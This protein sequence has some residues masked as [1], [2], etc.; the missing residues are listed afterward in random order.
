MANFDAQV[1]TDFRDVAGMAVS[2][3][4]DDIVEDTSNLGFMRKWTNRAPGLPSIPFIRQPGDPPPTY[5]GGR[6]GDPENNTHASQPAIIL[7]GGGRQRAQ[8]DRA[9]SCQLITDIFDNAGDDLLANQPF[10]CAYQFEKR[11][12]ASNG[13]AI[14]SVDGAPSEFSLYRRNGAGLGEINA[15]GVTTAPGDHADGTFVWT[16][17]GAAPGSAVW[18]Q[19]GA[20]YATGLGD[21]ESITSPAQFALGRA[22][23][24]NFLDGILDGFHLWMGQLSPL[25]LDFVWQTINADGVDYATQVR[26]PMNKPI[27]TD[28]TGDLAQSEINRL[29]PQTGVP[30]RYVRVELPVAPALHRVQVAAAVNGVVLPDSELGGDL[31][32]YT[33]VELP[34]PPVVTP[35]TAQDAGWSALADFQLNEE[36]HYTLGITRQDGGA[37]IVHF[38]V[39]VAT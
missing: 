23:G 1:R 10:S 8:F 12:D 26:A 33:W 2:L 15:G 35:I 18:Q 4:S 20:A 7:T 37:V 36:G 11:P 16:G 28:V 24:A 22:S 25:A 9:R 32:T 17:R 21:V 30:F 38:D 3:V 29:N 6:F 13:Q 19:D 27:W 5:L 39:Q 34:G 31:F 14:A